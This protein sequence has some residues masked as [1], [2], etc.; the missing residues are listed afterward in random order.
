MSC[1]HENM[2]NP[3]THHYVS[4]SKG[5]DSVDDVLDERNMSY[6]PIK[7]CILMDFSCNLPDLCIDSLNNKRYFS[8]YAASYFSND[9]DEL[10]KSEKWV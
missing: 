5:D 8:S 2:S 10:H 3:I 4:R 6:K 9:Y 7:I 1:G